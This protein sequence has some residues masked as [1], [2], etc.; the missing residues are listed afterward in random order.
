M[1]P[2]VSADAVRA[3]FEQSAPAYQSIPGLVRKHFLHAEDGGSGGGVYVW[4]SRA[5]AEAW[6][7]DTWVERVTAKFG[8]PQIDWFTSPVTVDADGVRSE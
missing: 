7:T 4:E 5:A 6:Y 8:P 3:S 1:D 2:S